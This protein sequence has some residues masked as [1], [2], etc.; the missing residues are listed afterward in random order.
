VTPQRTSV[1]AEVIETIAGHGP[2]ADA[3]VRIAR[4]ARAGRLD[5]FRDVV[6]TDPELD[7]DT[8]AWTLDLTEDEGLLLAV[9]LYLEHAR[10]P[11]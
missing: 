6:Q 10:Q 4:L 9:G 11:N 2:T 1:P 3:V 5:A 8:R 7:D